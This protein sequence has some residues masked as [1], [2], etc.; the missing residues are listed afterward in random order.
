MFNVP[1]NAKPILRHHQGFFYL[2]SP[3]TKY[4]A[5]HKKAVQ[6]AAYAAAWLAQEYHCA[7][8]SPIAH[9]AQLCATGLLDEVVTDHDFWMRQCLPLV[10]AS[11]GLLVL[12]LPGW[13]ESRG[14]LAEIEHAD[15]FD[16]PVIH[17]T[18][19]ML[20]LNGVIQA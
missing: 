17:I 6:H 3:F 12:D 14:V 5:G 18:P 9:S 15:K 8:Y 1:D 10:E 16:L 11:F 19:D 4:P 7:I 20:L 2:A 13:S